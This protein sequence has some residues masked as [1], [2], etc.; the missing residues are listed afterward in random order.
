VSFKLSLLP[1]GVVRK[2]C[3]GVIGNGVVLDPHALIAEITRIGEQGVTV[4]P[5]NLRIADNAPLI[6][7]VHRELDQLRE[8][9]NA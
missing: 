7:S 2:G 9:S 4:T 3:L 8:S 5:D 6:L 1:S